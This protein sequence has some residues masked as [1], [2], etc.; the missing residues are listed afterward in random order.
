MKK[1]L[2]QDDDS[3][4][5]NAGFDGGILYYNKKEK[6]IRYASANTPLFYVQNDELKMIA[7]DKHSVGYKRS[8]PNYPYKEH[9]INVSLGMSFY[10]TTDGYLDQNGGNKCLPFGKRRFKEIINSYHIDSMADQQEMFLY[11]LSEYEDEEERN[12]DITVIGFK[13]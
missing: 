9:I 11:E 3:S 1:L 2:Q 6:F 4:V 7:S 5:S 10:I 13:I 12:D 8:D